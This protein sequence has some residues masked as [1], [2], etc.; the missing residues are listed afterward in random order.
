M[1][2][3]CVEGHE[4][5]L[6]GFWIRDGEREYNQFVIRHKDI[7][8]EL[9]IDNDDRLIRFYISDDISEYEEDERTY[10]V[11]GMEALCR[12]QRCHSISRETKDL[13]N[14]LGVY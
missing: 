11:H 3:T 9:C 4:Y 1:S 13:L 8:P 10:W 14:S 12:V 2:S 7:F 5:M 6:I